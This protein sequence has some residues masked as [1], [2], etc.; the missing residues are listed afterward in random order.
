M[1]KDRLELDITPS[2][3]L[4]VLLALAH[5]LAISGILVSGVESYY[6]AAFAVAVF[7]SFIYCELRHGLLIDPLS[8]VTVLYQDEPWS[9]VCRHG[10]EITALLDL[11]VFVVSFLVVLNFK[12]AHGRKF[13]VAVFPDAVEAKQMRHCRIFLK[14]HPNLGGTKMVSV[15]SSSRSG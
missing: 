6:K 1:V 12:D 4:F 8:V 10:E 14:F 9:L 11:P 7:V 2:L 13:P 3:T 5:G 15:G